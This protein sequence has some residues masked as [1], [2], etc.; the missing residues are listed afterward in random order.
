MYKTTRSTLHD[1]AA[2]VSEKRLLNHAIHSF[3]ILHTVSLV[4]RM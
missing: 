3:Q 1:K 4:N 2:S